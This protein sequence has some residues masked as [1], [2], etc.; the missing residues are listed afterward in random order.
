M[1]LP[2]RKPARQRAPRKAP[3]SV[4]GL[5]GARSGKAWHLSRWT[6]VV[7]ELGL[8]FGG[9][10]A[11]DRWAF[12]GTAFA[13][14]E[15]H[16][17]T[18]VVL[19]FALIYGAGPGLAAAVVAGG[20]ALLLNPLRFAA[21]TDLFSHGLSLA[22]MPLVWIILAVVVGEVVSSRARIL[23]RITG[24][25]RRALRQYGRLERESRKLQAS[26]AALQLRIATEEKG[27]PETLEH[28]AALSACDV[29]D[30]RRVM[31]DL[32]ALTA[33]LA[34][35]RL[36]CRRPGTS[37]WICAIDRLPAHLGHAPADG[38]ELMQLL[39]QH[40]QPVHVGMRRH[41]AKLAPF[42]DI[43]VPLAG[44]KNGDEIDA[45]LVFGNVPFAAMTRGTI[46]WLT[47]LG[48]GL[49]RLLVRFPLVSADG[50]EFRVLREVTR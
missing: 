14:V 33:N 49:A 23:D 3:S 37:A 12:A 22:L 10:L 50:D 4:A 17:F 18:F 41:R 48:D 5:V 16:P 7:L 1:N 15:P 29:A 26:N 28:F 8:V 2:R 32:I 11:L 43:A 31:G 9:L 30:R 44:G 42:G 35:F 6:R 39:K 47:T 34:H 24:R 19:L 40:R 36:Y 27:L 38:P 13:G 45:V 21:S 25:Y 46:I 20:A